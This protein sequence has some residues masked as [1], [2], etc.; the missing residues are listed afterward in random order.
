M[1]SRLEEI[2]ANHE[3]RKDEG[4]EITTVTEDIDWLI[5]QAKKVELLEKRLNEICQTSYCIVCGDIATEV[6]QGQFY[7]EE[8]CE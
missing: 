2:K 1:K 4:W 8:C 5:E 7:C 6:V 3:F